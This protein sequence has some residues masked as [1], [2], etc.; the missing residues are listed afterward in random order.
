VGALGSTVLAFE[1]P[2]L[3][4]HALAP[5]IVLFATFLVV[6]FADLAGDR[7]K[8]VLASLT[9]IG[10]LA[11]LVPVL[12]LGIDEAGMRS[13]FGGGYVVDDFS[14]V[15]K[16][17]FVL[18]A[19]V[20]VLLSTNYVAEGDYW[21]GEY[22]LMVIA[23]TLGMVVMASSR[24]LIGIFVAL[25]LLSI[26]AYMLA[27][28]RKRDA[29][30]NEAGL[31]YYLM[32]VFATAV[33][34]YGMSLIFGITGSTDLAD[35]GVALDTGESLPA[36]TLAIVFVVVGFGFKVSAVPFHAWAPDTYEG[37]PT[38]ITAFLS[39]SSKAAGF[40]ALA[41]LTLVGFWGQSEVWQPLFWVL[42]A[43]SM[44]IGNLVALRQT[45]IVRLF[46]YSSVAQ[47]GY[48]LAPLAVAGESLEARAT[49]I[50]AMVVYLLIYGAMN[51]GA[52]A[53]VI[54]VARK[55]PLRGDDGLPV[56]PRRHP[57]PRRLVRQVR[58]VPGAGHP[59]HR[60]GLHPGGHPRREL[61]HR[62]L[63]LRPHRPEDVDGAGARRR[64]LADPRA[65][66]AGGRPGPV[67]HR[68]A[69]ARRVPQPRG[70]PRRPRRARLP[71]RLA[72]IVR[73]SADRPGGGRTHPATAGERPAAPG[74]RGRAAGARAPRRRPA[75]GA[76]PRL[77]RRGG[78]RGPG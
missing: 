9:G 39:V 7:F 44:T 35:I 63:L 72:L 53:V 77:G 3:D 43:A 61:R 49:S 48:I 70:R 56:R 50:G 41:S 37:A 15:L 34:L 18:A 6:F 26:P 2:S 14:L 52:F 16:G 8:P 32:G 76:G 31:K 36:L 30:S 4:Y 27:A 47:G 51:L 57:A 23:S 59:G 73:R 21:E 40:V 11:A 69:R 1:A 19:Y 66:L 12:T 60:G 28:W 67:R 55:T 24:D 58:R 65:A 54:A 42:S 25:E 10:L 46:A 17:L 38:P 68:H 22:Y 5:E 62:A 75:G 45:N 33:M 71:L 13:M 74:P 78:R 64:P 29:K 20:V